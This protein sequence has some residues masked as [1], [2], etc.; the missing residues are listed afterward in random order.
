MTQWMVMYRKEALEMWR[1]YK[2]LWV[3]LV[4]LLLG[5]MQPVTY[6]YMPTIL[7]SMGNLPEGTSITMTVP[8]APEVIYSTLSNLNTTGILVL[9]L[10]CMGMISGE[11]SRGVAE[12]ILVKPVSAFHFISTKWAAMI[13][14][15]TVSYLLG[16]AGAWYYTALLIGNVHIG[17]FMQAIL[18]YGLWLIFAVTVAIFFG[19]MLRNAAGIAALSLISLI[20]LSLLGGLFDK[21]MAWSPSRLP[22]YAHR[23]LVEQHTGLGLLGSLVLTLL[24]IAALLTASIYLF[25]SKEVATPQ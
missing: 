10:A 18:V 12:L 3:P 5:A 13:T 19:S 9:V 11:R 16:M 24:V 7:D 8:S 15:T 14:L 1:S 21:M 2:C 23:L 6:Y 25:G 20:V 17:I 4:F 22:D